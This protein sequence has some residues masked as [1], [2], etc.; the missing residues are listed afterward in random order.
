M[1][2]GKQTVAERLAARTAQ[3]N[4]ARNENADTKQKPAPRR[5]AQQHAMSYNKPTAVKLPSADTPSYK[6][7]ATRT[8]VSQNIISTK[9]SINN[10]VMEQLDFN[11]LNRLPEKERNEQ[12]FGLIKEVVDEQNVILNAVE[13]QNLLALFI[14]DMFGFGPLESLLEDDT[15]T[16]IMVNAPDQVYVERDGMLQ[17][18]NVRF[19]DKQHIMNVAVRIASRVG[20]RVDESNPMVD[21]RLEDG[22]RVNIIAPPLA[23][24]SPTI[25]IRKFSNKSITLDK[26]VQQGNMSVDMATFIKIAARSGL[27]IMISGGTGTGKTTLLNAMSEHIDKR[28]RIVTIEDAAELRLKQPHV[29]TLE[30]RPAN[31]EGTGQITI[32]DLLINSLRMRPDRIIVG[33]V[34]GAEVVDMLQAMNTGHDGSLGTIHSNT[35]RDALSRLENLYWMSGLKMPLM[36]LRAQIASAIDLIVQVS[37]MRDGKRRITSIVEVC[38]LEG[39][40]ITTQELFKYVQR[41]EN[42]HGL[43]GD[44]VSTG[45]R[46]KAFDKIMQAGLDVQVAE[47]IKSTRLKK[48]V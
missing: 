23:F 21:A 2:K 4:A 47:L 48:D 12:L 28:E 35:P 16:D 30:S 22:S 34:R 13:L 19:R 3:I 11:V 5:A 43:V 25:S 40:I 33:E 41:G 27:N 39:E 10:R 26:M 1:E 37:R 45:L 24:K 9:A 14:D 31:L 46:P 8:A 32:R 44:F 36:A 15:V 6:A 18:T 29:V 17:L 38:G 7:K 42:Q 20:R